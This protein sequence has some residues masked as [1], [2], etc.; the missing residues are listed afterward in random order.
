MLKDVF[1]IYTEYL[2]IFIWVISQWV[3]FDVEVF[4]QKFLE[5]W[6]GKSCKELTVLLR[7]LIYEYT[8]LDNK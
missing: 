4:I 8:Y 3:S 6:S 7:V 2:N 5:M 1:I